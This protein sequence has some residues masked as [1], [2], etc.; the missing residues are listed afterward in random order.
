M[1]L[2]PTVEWSEIATLAGILAA[3]AAPLAWVWQDNRRAIHHLHRRLDALSAQL[4]ADKLEAART[5]VSSEAVMRVEKRLAAS[6]V[7]MAAAIEA[8]G[9]R[10]DRALEAALSRPRS[11]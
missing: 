10:I 9:G 8:L 3:V 4:A 1:G 6:E 11:S 2:G 5:F 7:R